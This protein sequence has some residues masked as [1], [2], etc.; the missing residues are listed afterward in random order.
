MKFLTFTEFS[1][2]IYNSE[3]VYFLQDDWRF[4][5]KE[6]TGEYNFSSD[7]F[8]KEIPLE[9]IDDVERDGFVGCFHLK[10][11]NQT[12]NSFDPLIFQ[13]S[14]RFYFCAVNPCDLLKQ[15]NNDVLLLFFNYPG[16]TSALLEYLGKIDRELY[17][18][19]VYVDELDDYDTPFILFDSK[20]PFDRSLM[21]DRLNYVR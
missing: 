17:D 5:K 7:S 21:L 12:L 10:K 19:I 20:N 16:T 3:N 2:L 13:P 15:F 14:I 6:F 11:N 1:E 18:W 9:A 8:V 4:L